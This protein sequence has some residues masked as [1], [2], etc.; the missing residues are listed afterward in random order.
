MTEALRAGGSPGEVQAAVLP[1]LQQ[2]HWTITVPSQNTSA[3]ARTAATW[4][5]R[6]AS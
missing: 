5:R 4:P 3:S 2:A 6:S 1:A